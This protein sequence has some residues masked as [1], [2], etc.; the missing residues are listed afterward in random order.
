MDGLMMDRQLLIKRLLWRGERIFGDKRVVSRTA[1]GYHEYTY[2]EFGHRV[3][4][5]AGALQALGIAPG[6]RVATLAW[7][8]HRHL[9]CYFAVP[10]MGAVLHT[11]NH[12]LSEDQLAYTI[13]HAGDR[14]VFV[15]PDLVPLLESIADRLP[16]VRCYVVLGPVPEDTTLTPAFSY[17]DLLAEAAPVGLPEFDEN[18]AASLCYTSGTTGD[19]KGV[20]Y[21]HRSMVLHALA[22][23]A[24]GSA[25]IAEEDTYLVVT[26]MSHVNAWGTP[27]ACTL[28]GATLVLPGIHPSPEDLLRTI[29]DRRPSTVVAAVTVGTMLKDAH[30]RTGRRY[31]LDS[32]RRLWL[33]GQAPPAALT[34]WWRRNNDTVVVN[35]WGMTETSPIATFAENTLTQ[36]KP[37]PL[38]EMRITGEDGR[39]LPWDG[40]TV[41]EL[42][43][44]SPWVAR[45]YYDDPR[46]V[47][48]FRDGW[49]R[50][51]DVSVFAPDGSMQLKDRSK[52]L[53]KSGGEWISSVDLE[54]ALMAHP[55]VREAV[56][57]AIPDDTWLERPLACVEAQGTV[58]AEELRNH[59]RIRFARYWVPDHIVFVR[60]IP[61]TSVGKFDKKRLRACYLADG[62]DGVRSL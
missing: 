10:G 2:T 1:S 45:E 11:A 55:M 15:D 48:S 19:P 31:R 8:T 47:D 35:G 44:R 22:L 51:G 40:E 9:E 3:R 43:V 25:E 6:D 24:R 13:D 32:L 46:T 59:L 38:V 37:L 53:I 16:S 5:L 28:Q 62:L 7:N 49:L 42:E 41:G 20:V 33:G 57:I 58:T 30:E 18:T 36:G 12:R 34:E 23:C 26:P 50:T 54:N 52:D 29:H 61:K 60:R 4:R 56:V 27:Y 21:S 14:A 39:E 17:E